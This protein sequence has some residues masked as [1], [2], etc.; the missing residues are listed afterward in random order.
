[1]TLPNQPDSSTQSN[2][3]VEKEDTLNVHS[4]AIQSTDDADKILPIFRRL[5]RVQGLKRTDLRVKN[6]IGKANI[7]SFLEKFGGNLHHF[8]LDS[9]E[10][11]RE[12]EESNIQRDGGWESLGCSNCTSLRFIAF[13][14]FLPFYTYELYAICLQQIHPLLSNFTKSSHSIESITIGLQLGFYRVGSLMEKMEL[15]DWTRLDNLLVGRFTKLAKVKFHFWNVELEP[16]SE[17]VDSVYSDKPGGRI[18]DDQVE[19]IAN[20]LPVCRSKGILVFLIEG[21]SIVNSPRSIVP[22]NYWDAI[23]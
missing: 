11:V 18:F 15:V 22:E 20:N 4:L 7:R 10:M 16:E 6:S 23:R 5:I 21:P 19:F 9:C 17:S 1:M 14:L 12:I 2:V 8:R 3:C 13:D